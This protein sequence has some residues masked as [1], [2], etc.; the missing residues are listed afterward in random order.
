MVKKILAV[1]LSM[2]M[3]FSLAACGNKEAEEKGDYLTGNKWESTKGMLLELNKE[4]D[5]KFFR[6]K[7]DREDNYYTGTFSVISGAEAVD[8]LE[9][10]HE[11]SQE[12]QRNAMAQFGVDENNYYVL[13]L[14]NKECIEGGTNTLEEENPVTY[15]GYYLPDY[16]YLNLYNLKTMGQYEFYKK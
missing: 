12:N 1:M 7:S 11:L 14:N 4:G 10:N 3:I 8:Y 6:D 5:F 13:I 16:D 15:Y 2:I 9:E